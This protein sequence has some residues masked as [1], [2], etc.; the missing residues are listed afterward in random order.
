MSNYPSTV[1][2]SGP[3][4]EVVEWVRR[5]RARNIAEVGI[6][7]GMTTRLIHKELAGEGTLDIFDFQARVDAVAQALPRTGTVVRTHGNSQRFL[8]SYCWSLMRV[9]E[10]N[11]VPIW[12]FVFLDGAHTWAI[13]GFAVL[14]IDR[15]LRPGGHIFLDDYH[16][17]LAGSPSLNPKSFPLTAKM[18]TAEQ[19]GTKQVER[20][21][22]LLLERS[23]YETV[24]PTKLWRKPSG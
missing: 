12:D 11:S 2:V 15:L 18:Y 16:W 7:K 22:T 1:A 5:L 19:I 8:D 23:G 9:L 24:V 21:A 14:L 3:R 20:V 6:Y 10:K 17:T 13:D 4:T